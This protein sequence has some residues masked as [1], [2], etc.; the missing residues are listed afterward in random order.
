M[1]ATILF[2]RSL[3]SLALLLGLLFGVVGVAAEPVNFY[4]SVSD[5]FQPRMILFD[6]LTFQSSNN[7]AEA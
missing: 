5:T 7:F 3:V 2:L 6:P 4:K 1:S